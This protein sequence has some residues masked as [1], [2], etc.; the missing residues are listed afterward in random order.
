MYIGKDGAM[1]GDKQFDVD[2]DDSTLIDGIRYIS[3]SGLY[4]LIFKKIPD[5]LVYTENDKLTYKS[6]L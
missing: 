1:L 4:E 3:T 5:S 6:I 2:A